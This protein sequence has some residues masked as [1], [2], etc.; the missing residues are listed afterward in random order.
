[1]GGRSTRLAAILLLAAL[2][3]RSQLHDV[4]QKLAGDR[5]HTW[6]F[7]RMEVIMGGDGRCKA[8]ETWR[9]SSNH[10]VQLRMCQDGKV[11]VSNAK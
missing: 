1:M 10:E 9:F 4:E 6:V 2:V 3:A 7:A 8:G 5:D 11:V